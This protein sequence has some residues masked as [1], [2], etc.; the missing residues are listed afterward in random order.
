MSG[1][2][3]I[4]SA[5]EVSSLAQDMVGQYFI[6]FAA[7][8]VA[9]NP[10]AEALAPPIKPGEHSSI[11]R[12]PRRDGT[13]MSMLFLHYLKANVDQ[14][15]KSDFDKLWFRGALLTVNDALGDNGYFGHVPEA[16]MVRHLRN[17]IGHRNRFTFGPGVLNK[18]TGKLKHPANT[19]EMWKVFRHPRHE[20]ESHLEGTEVLWTW[21]GPDGVLDCLTALALRLN[22][23]AT[24]V[25]KRPNPSSP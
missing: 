21:G 24:D 25:E 14:K 3:D 7:M 13:E 5:R 22:T 12:I 20:I 19:H 4:K 2:L 16:E 23:M 17:G 15:V 10:K 8:Y 18:L 9:R 6:H 1:T 11:L